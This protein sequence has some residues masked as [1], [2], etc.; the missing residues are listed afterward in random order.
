MPA[1]LADAGLPALNTNI[2]KNLELEE[3][4]KEIKENLGNLKKFCVTLCRKMTEIINHNNLVNKSY[5]N[6]EHRNSIENFF[7]FLFENSNESDLVHFGF[8]Q[9]VE[10]FFRLI[11]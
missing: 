3:Y 1:S 5:P 9:L 7:T 11:R 10:V 8:S 6:Y 2:G 4:P